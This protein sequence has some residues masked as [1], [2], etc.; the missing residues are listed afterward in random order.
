MRKTGCLLAVLAIGFVVA[1]GPAPIAF[2][3]E[4]A[5][6]AEEARSIP[7][8][9]AFEE[10]QDEEGVRTLADW[11]RLG[12]FIMYFLVAC[13]IV[14]FALSLERSWSLRRGQ[15]IPRTFTR[16]LRDHVFRHDIRKIQ[17]LCEPA[18]SSISRVLKA[19]L[20][21]FDEGLGRVGDAIETAGAH[22][23]TLL[24]RNLAMLGAIANIAT[25][26]GLLGTVLG[27][28][29]SFDLIAKTGTGDAR[30][31]AA[32][33]FQALVTTAA[34]LMVGIPTI[35]L[36][37]YF[38][39]KAEV[40]VIELEEVSFGILQALAGDQPSTGTDPAEA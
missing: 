5:G 2:A 12:G 19:G 7:G 27:M 3:Q 28:I 20:I 23:Q 39:R 32:G 37:S 36:Y 6:A 16:Q 25:M 11:Y 24:R 30:V 35:A 1:A 40:L 4:A 31:V 34:G 29:T 26:L 22:E 8:T 10:A 38:R 21:H 18:R 33:I 9:Q 14:A 17:E 15:V 13:S